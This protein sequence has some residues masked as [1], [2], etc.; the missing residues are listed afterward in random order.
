MQV[1]D[2]KQQENIE[3][4]QNEQKDTIKDNNT[5]EEELM[6][7]VSQMS[8]DLNDLTIEKDGFKEQISVQKDY[9]SRITKESEAQKKSSKSE[10]DDLQK[11]IQVLLSF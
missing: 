9:I 10:S 2:L 1:K 4:L 11:Q 3:I 8:K 7:D 6:S 5:R